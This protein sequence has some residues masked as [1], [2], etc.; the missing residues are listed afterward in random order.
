MPIKSKEEL[1]RELEHKLR[2]RVQEK[3]KAEQPKQEKSAKGFLSNLKSDLTQFSKGILSLGRQAITHPIQST[4]TVAGLGLEVAKGMPKASVDFAKSA[5]D[6]IANPVERTKEVIEGYQKLRAIPYNEQKK[7]IEETLAAVSSS[8][9]LNKNQKILAQLGTAIAGDIGHEVTH[10]AEFMY[11]KPFTFG[12]DILS[13]GGGKVV[14]KGVKV[15]KPMLKETKL[16]KAIEEVVV[17][18]A[19][20]VRAGYKKFA[21][22]LARTSGTIYKMQEGVIKST[23]KKFEKTFG[24]SGKERIEFFD[25]IDALRREDQFLKPLNFPDA[26]PIKGDLAKTRKGM[27]ELGKRE[28]KAKNLNPQKKYFRD[29]FGEV[30]EYGRD[31][32]K[33]AVSKNPKIQKAIDWWLKEELPK[34]QKAAGIPDEY[35]ITNY[36]HHLFPERVS[37]AEKAARPMRSQRGFLKKSKDV[38]GFSKDPVVSISAIKIKTAMANMKDSFIRRAEAQYGKSIKSFEQQLYGKLGPEKFEKLKKSGKLVD[39]IKREFNIESFS[40]SADEVIWFPKEIADELNKVYGFNKVSNVI[41]KLMAP[42]DFFNR[43]WKPLATAVRPRYHTRNIVGNLYNSIVVGGMNQT[44]IPKAMRQ[45]LAGYLNEARNSGGK[46]G[47]LAKKLFPNKLNDKYLRY[48]LKDEVVGRGFFS[49]DLHDMSKAV[50]YSEDIIKTVNRVKEPAEIYKIPILKQYLNLSKNIGSAIEDNARLSLYID[51]LRKGASRKAAKEYVNKHLFDYLQGLGDG[52]KI[53]KR[54]IPFWS[55]QRFNTPL[56]LGS[57]FTKPKRMAVIQHGTSGHVRSQEALDENR[58]FLTEKEKEAGLFK[59]GEVE[60]NGKTLD[61]YMRTQSVLPQADLVRLVDYFSLN[62]DDIG[63]NPVFSLLSRLNK[64]RDYWGNKIEEFEGEEGLFLDGAFNKKTIEWL[65]IIPILNEINKLTGG[66]SL[67]ELAPLGI[68][69]EQVLSPL[70]ISVKDPEEMKY[71]GLLKEEQELKGSYESGLESLYSKYYAKSKIDPDQKVYQENIKKLEKI[72]L[73]KGLTKMNLV[74]LKINA[75]KRMIKEKMRNKTGEK[76]DER[77]EKFNLKTIQLKV[78]DYFEPTDELRIRDIT[79]ELW[80]LITPQIPQ[81]PEEA[82]ELGLRPMQG[83]PLSPEGYGLYMD[84]AGMLIHITKDGGMGFDPL[85][86]V[87]SMKAAT[88]AAGKALKPTVYAGFKDLSSKVLRQLEGKFR[89]SKQFITDLLKKKDIKAAEKEII[90]E[91]LGEYSGKR[92]PVD[93][94]ANKVKAKLLPLEYTDDLDIYE[95]VALPD[96]LRGNVKQYTE[97]IYDSPIQNRAGQIHFAEGADIGIGKNYFAHSRVET[98]EDGTRRIIELQSDLFQRGRLKNEYSNVTDTIKDIADQR[99][100][101]AHVVRG[102]ELGR[103]EPYKNIWHERLIREEIKDAAQVGTKKVQFPT[104]KT[105]MKIEGLEINSKGWFT[106]WG[107]DV[108]RDVLA[109]ERDLVRGF[110][111]ENA[112]T[113]E[114]FIITKN[115]GNGKFKAVNAMSFEMRMDD[116]FGEALPRKA[117]TEYFDDAVKRIQ[118]EDEF[119]KIEDFEESFDLY[120]KV[121]SHP[122]YDFYEKK[123]QKYL[124][125]VKPEMKRITDEQGVEWF[126]IPITEKD[127]TSPVDAFSKF[128]IPGAMVNE[129]LETPDTDEEGKEVEKTPESIGFLKYHDAAK[130]FFKKQV[131]QTERARGN[132]KDEEPEKKEEHKNEE[133]E[134]PKNPLKTKQAKAEEPDRKKVLVNRRFEGKSIEADVNDID[135]LKEIYKVNKDWGKKA[136]IG[137]IDLTTHKYATNPDHVRAISQIYDQVKDYNIEQMENEFK[138]LGS[139]LQ[140]ITDDL[141]QILDHFGV[142]PGEFIAVV[143]QDSQAGTTGAGAR[144]KNPGNIGNTDDGSTIQFGTWIEGATAAIRNL[145][146][147]KVRE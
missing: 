3:R 111:I 114:T 46:V 36:L 62:T 2:T 93:E 25:T 139:Q 14:G 85:G 80:E 108:G 79:R 82:K 44:Q 32:A 143:R 21:D 83:S 90:E 38:A 40:K 66:S 121:E 68:R 43:N 131:E 49:I 118:K 10:P 47:A 50:N 19:K 101:G 51:Q 71:F 12:L 142:T 56:Q 126:E 33:T 77:G 130:E 4:K 74:P 125:K 86:M 58:E 35:K 6:L 97:K 145:A 102:E 13:A 70:G 9:K 146:E 115:L 37:K 52:D 60:V 1:K 132:I 42:L 18:N 88:G 26:P 67:K 20:L 72:L 48:A 135:T 120:G 7:L 87:G 92:V 65:K 137:N 140:Y 147:R 144:T 24:L 81:T 100:V 99:G 15:T 127:L 31:F 16:V 76:I 45:Q 95:N 27:T 73:D 103:L 124:K 23:A 41:E 94:L 122:I 138:R 22:D 109:R 134:E 136:T 84:G 53:I 39:T 105:A 112:A 30:Y 29:K 96:K 91:V 113:E 98:M 64:N 89:V 117:S 28:L 34:V 133:K 106:Q 54:F 63:L 55:W 116:L 11:D 141:E 75:M 5:G 57:V 128:A 78:Q 59:I 69:L 104:G 119:F 129:Y 17:P 107:D 8:D 110:E 61:K 123:V